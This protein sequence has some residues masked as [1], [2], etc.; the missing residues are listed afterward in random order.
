MRLGL[1]VGGFKP[2]TS[3]HYSKIALAK[4]DCEIVCVIHST[5]DRDD[6]KQSSLI[7]MW[8]I[9]DSHLRKMGV[10]PVECARTPVKDA[11]GVIGTLRERVY[12]KRKNDDILP[13]EMFGIKQAVTG[14][15][16]Y[17]SEEDIHIN[18]SR[19]VGT[20]D[21]AKYFGDLVKD[22]RLTFVT[23]SGHTTY[24]NDQGA[25]DLSDIRATEVRRLL[26]RR[27]K[28]AIKYFP[29]FLS[30]DDKNRMFEI[31]SSRGR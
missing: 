31:L 25:R 22:S 24:G 26:S 17:G 8:Q 1:F 2:F 9:L 20:P 27:D 15:A 19:L 3:G 10:I 6:L 13:F 29:P 18:F 5:K 16:I 14:I 28:S 21:E 30:D 7:A 12:S 4:R 11:Y 23:E